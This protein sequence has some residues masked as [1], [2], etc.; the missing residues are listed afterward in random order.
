MSI[1]EH[2]VIKVGQMWES[3]VIKYKIKILYNYDGHLCYK[4]DDSDGLSI[5]DMYTIR[6]LLKSWKNITYMQSPLYK[7][8]ENIDQGLKNVK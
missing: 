3:K 6:I 2:D 1:K 5:I 8:L 4:Y 7:V